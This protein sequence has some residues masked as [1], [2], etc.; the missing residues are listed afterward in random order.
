MNNNDLYRS[1]DTYESILKELMDE[2]AVWLSLLK[3]AVQILRNR[4]QNENTL[5]PVQQ[6]QDAS[7]PWLLFSFLVPFCK[8]RTGKG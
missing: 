8:I 5:I 1:D 3:L 4:E 6:I 7:N 2:T